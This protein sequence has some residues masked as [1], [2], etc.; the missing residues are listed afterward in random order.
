MRTPVLAE[1]IAC[2][3][4]ENEVKKLDCTRRGILP[5]RSCVS[6]PGLAE[7]EHRLRSYWDVGVLAQAR[8]LNDHSEG[9]SRS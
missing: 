9:T 2:N 3:V 4:S 1:G 7:I 8:E 6:S 5:M